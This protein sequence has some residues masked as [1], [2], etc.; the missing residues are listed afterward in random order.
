MG[1]IQAPQLLDH[2]SAD[3]PEIARVSGDRYFRDLIDEAVTEPSDHALDDSLAFAAR[4]ARCYDIEAFLG[5][6]PKRFDHFRG[7]LQIDVDN[8][9]P[10]AAAIEDARHRC[11]RLAEAPAE[12]HEADVGISADFVA[13]NKLRSVRRRIEGEDDLVSDEALEHWNRARQEWPNVAL[14]RVN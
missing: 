2:A 9:A 7:V 5:L 3:Q 8:C 13:N 14:L 1:L 6:V 4:A 10:A 11:R 12:H